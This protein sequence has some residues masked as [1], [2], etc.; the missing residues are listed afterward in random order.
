[1]RVR[2]MV[3][4]RPSPDSTEEDPLKD[5][6]LVGAVKRVSKRARITAVGVGVTMFLGPVLALAAV[7]WW[8][9]ADLR[10][11]AEPGILLVWGFWAA[12]CAWLAAQPWTNALDVRKA[13]EVLALFPQFAILELGGLFRPRLVCLAQAQTSTSPRVVLRFQ[14][15]VGDE[16]TRFELDVPW[17]WPA[18]VVAFRGRLYTDLPGLLPELAALSEEFAGGEHLWT[19]LAENRLVTTV[20]PGWGQLRGPGEPTDSVKARIE[21]RWAALESLY[22]LAGLETAFSPVSKHEGGGL[23]R[24][25]GPFSLSAWCPRC[26][27]T[28]SIWARRDYGPCRRCGSRPIGVLHDWGLRR[29]LDGKMERA[30]RVYRF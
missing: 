3:T 24:V 18:D 8:L 23:P 29:T 15:A 2:S 10:G 6:S 13:G 7:I 16:P 30:A 20:L 19:K 27:R 9:G 21:R 12:F 17:C 22:R 4:S 28:A 1:M 26:R 11:L 5:L 25:I 14:G